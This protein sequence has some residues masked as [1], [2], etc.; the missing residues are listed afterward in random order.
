MSKVSFIDRFAPNTFD[1]AKVHQVVDDNIRNAPIMSDRVD[2]MYS[3]HATI[4][5]IETALNDPI[6][7]IRSIAR[8]LIT[9]SLPSHD[10]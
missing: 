8:Q 9:Q 6:P 7:L 3:P 5:H 1:V 10:E 4:D 2:A